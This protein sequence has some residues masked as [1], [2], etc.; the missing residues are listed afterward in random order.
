MLNILFALMSSM[1]LP[2]KLVEVRGLPVGGSE[3]GDRKVREYPQNFGGPP[4]VQGALCDP[5]TL[6]LVNSHEL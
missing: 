4:P 1:Y 3:D 5:L 6:A 2:G